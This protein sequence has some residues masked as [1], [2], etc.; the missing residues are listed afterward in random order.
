MIS[1][2]LW[3]AEM[4]PRAGEVVPFSPI[5]IRHGKGN[6]A[7][8]MAGSWRAL[9]L[10]RAAS[11]GDGV[12]LQVSSDVRNAL[13]S[14]HAQHVGVLGV[15][16]PPATG[17]RLL[18]NTLLQPQDVDL[19]TVSEGDRDVLLW[20]WLPEEGARQ[21]GDALRVVLAAGATLQAENDLQTENQRLA[22]LLLLSSALLYNADGEINAE[23]V[24]RL[25]WVEKVAQVLR[26]KGV[27]DEEAVGECGEDTREHDCIIEILTTYLIDALV[28]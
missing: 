5:K 22:L 26:I 24:E 15:F 17:K 3:V 13:L 20:L 7:A 23:A 18:L 14:I 27:Q 25:Q 11:S 6:R 19:S 28:L 8:P 16:G 4:G 21:D 10:I 1:S 2:Q 9:P 12:A